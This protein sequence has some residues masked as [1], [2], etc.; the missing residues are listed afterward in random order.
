MKINKV[1]V[2]VITSV[3]NVCTNVR[4]RLSWQVFAQFLQTYDIEDINHLK[5]SV[6]K[7]LAGRS[8]A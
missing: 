4:H 6:N 7:T 3:E 2:D 1:S 8:L 5:R